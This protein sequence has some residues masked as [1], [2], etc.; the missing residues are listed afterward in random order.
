MLKHCELKDIHDDEISMAAGDIG[1]ISCFKPTVQFGYSGFSGNCHG[2]DLCIVDKNR[3]YL[4]PAE[5]VFDT[6]TYLASHQE[7]VDRIKKE[8]KPSMTKQEYLEF[9]HGE[10]NE[11]AYGQWQNPI[12][13]IVTG[14]DRIK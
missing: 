11:E 3:A 5:V 14:P 6:V 12:L 1:D 10:F 13:L 7:Y 2:K 8:F 4:E 9:L